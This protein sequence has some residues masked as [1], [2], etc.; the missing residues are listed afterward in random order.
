MFTVLGKEFKSLQQASAHFG[1][2]RGALTKKSKE[3]SSSEELDAWLSSHLKKTY[4][5]KASNDEELKLLVL[6]NSV[7]NSEGC[8]LWQGRVNHNGYGVLHYLGH[9]STKMHR[10]SYR[11]FKGEI[12]EGL[13]VRHRCHNKLCCNPLHL[14][15]GTHRDNALDAVVDGVKSVYDQQGAKNP[16]AN[17]TE[18]QVYELRVKYATEEF[19]TTKLA[20]MY[21]ISRKNVSSCVNGTYY[22]CYQNVPPFDWRESDKILFR[23]MLTRT[24][25]NKIQEELLS[26]K[27]VDDVASELG[28][29]IQ[30][31]QKI[32]NG[33]HG[34]YDS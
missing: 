12:P 25:Y 7:E 10:H 34:H 28:V 8:W 30:T 2:D 16:L 15:V 5:I 14:E 27:Q 32:F 33:E 19:S 6:N 23:N 11:I 31:V 20:K 4:Y 26:G 18:Q 13:L 3:L 17:L 21:G 1:L 9:R 22:S 24:G 29:P